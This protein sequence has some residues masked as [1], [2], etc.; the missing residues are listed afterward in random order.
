MATERTGTAWLQIR[1]DGLRE[2]K[3]TRVTQT[4]PDQIHGDAYLVKVRLRIPDSAFKGP[5]AEIT[6]PEEALIQPV[7]AEAIQEQRA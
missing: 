2:L 5:V 1:P 3:V 4:R 6:V 7:E